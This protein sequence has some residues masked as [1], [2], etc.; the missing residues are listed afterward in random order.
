[1]YWTISTVV[2]AIA[3]MG[4]DKG[5]QLPQPGGLL[6]IAY[7][8][9]LMKKEGK[10]VNRAQVQFDRG[11][12]RVGQ[13]F[14]TKQFS[15]TPVCFEMYDGMPPHVPWTVRT[16]SR[17]ASPNLI[18]YDPSGGPARRPSGWIVSRTDLRPGE[19]K[20]LK[21]ER[22]AGQ[23]CEVWRGK[24]PSVVLQSPNPGPYSQKVWLEPRS[25]L[26]LKLEE[27]NDPP[28]GSTFPRIRRLLV[29]E[30]IRFVDRFPPETFQLTPGT[31]AVLQTAFW[32]TP[33]PPGVRRVRQGS[34]AIAKPR[35]RA[36][37]P[38]SKSAK[39]SVKP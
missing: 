36:A 33:L 34:T 35:S 37:E 17:L 22:V 32:D 27:G 4:S 26:V 10:T 3:V 30:K 24:S 16:D 7:E 18:Y 5:S 14:A 2:C 23:L 12:Y 13:I 28:K 8:A 1:M 19:W 38:L 11:K 25:K 20:K 31:T 39:A 9:S 21:Q 6:N 29:V 15:R